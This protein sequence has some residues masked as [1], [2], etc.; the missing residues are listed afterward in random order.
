MAASAEARVRRQVRRVSGADPAL[1]KLKGPRNPILDPTI[2][3]FNSE[4]FSQ[5]QTEF[6]NVD[7]PFQNAMRAMRAFM[8][9]SAF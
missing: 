2:F 1:W 4:I 6:S 9:G 5:C 3:I 8:G 7:V